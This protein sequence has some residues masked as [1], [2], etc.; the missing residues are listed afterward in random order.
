VKLYSRPG[1]DLTYRFPLIV[2]AA[3]LAGGDGDGRLFPAD[4][5]TARCL[6]L[7]IKLS[8][9]SV[10]TAMVLERGL[11]VPKSNTLD[12]I[13]AG[14]PAMV[15]AFG[16]NGFPVESPSWSSTAHCRNHMCITCSAQMTRMFAM[17]P[18]LS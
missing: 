8:A 12:T 6:G 4:A 5:T 9:R 7:E 1:N 14:T 18:S 16:Y 17:P 13:K 2:A 11:E 10:T 15:A 3:F